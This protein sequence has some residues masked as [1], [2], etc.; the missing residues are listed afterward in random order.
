MRAL[1]L[2]RLDNC[3]S[4]YYGLPDVLLQKLQR[5]MIFASRLI[6]RL[7]LWHTN[8]GFYSADA[9][10]TCTKTHSFQNFF[11]WFIVWFTFRRGFQIILTCLESESL[12][13][14]TKTKNFTLSESLDSNGNWVSQ[15]I[16]LFRAIFLN[17]VFF[18]F[19]WIF[20]LLNHFCRVRILKQKL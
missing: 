11:W 17:S 9:L 3:N 16:E 10:V 18:V 8:Y 5:I 4:V 14:N 6:F 7:S 2:T 12:L 15:N 19:S 1:V 20:A 13:F